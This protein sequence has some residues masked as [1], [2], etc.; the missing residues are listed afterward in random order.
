[1]QTFSLHVLNQTDGATNKMKFS[2]Q[3]NITTSYNA[4]QTSG[5]R[6]TSQLKALFDVMKRRTKKDKSSEKVN[7]FKNSPIKHNYKKNIE[8][9]MLCTF[10]SI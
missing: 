3:E 9:L 6:T 8:L 2:V 10:Y 5:T 1:M 4:L 7:Y